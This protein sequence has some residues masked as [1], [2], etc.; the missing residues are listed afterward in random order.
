M[1]FLAIARVDR[2]RLV[3]I[4]VHSIRALIIDLH[5]HTRSHGAPVGGKRIILGC[6][7]P[8]LA[9]AFADA[10]GYV[11]G[12]AVDAAGAE[13]VAAGIGEI[14]GGCEASAMEACC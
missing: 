14:V 5:H 13:V 1:D 8:A 9:A 2:M 3:L 11:A 12:A 7:V 10:G 4:T 6:N